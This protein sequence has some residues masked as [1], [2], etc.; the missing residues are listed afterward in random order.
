[1]EKFNF[2]IHLIHERLVKL[3][4]ETSKVLIK[5]MTHNKNNGIS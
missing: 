2:I 3:L 1:M 5:T 4:N